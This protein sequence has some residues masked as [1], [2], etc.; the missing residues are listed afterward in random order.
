[1]GIGVGF[2]GDEKNLRP[3]VQAKFYGITVKA[4]SASIADRSPLALVVS[5]DFYE[6]TIQMSEM[7]RGNAGGIY[8]RTSASITL[9]RWKARRVLF[10]GHQGK[11]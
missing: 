7:R 10:R 9:D 11:R 1:L 3:V 4:I 5:L 2:I 6:N 8:S